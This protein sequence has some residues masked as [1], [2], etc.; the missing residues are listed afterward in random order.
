MKKSRKYRWISL[1]LATFLLLQLFGCGTS[2]ISFPADDDGGFDS[3]TESTTGTSTISVLESTGTTATTTATTTT[4]K[5][6]TKT[7]TQWKFYQVVS[8]KEDGIVVD[9]YKNGYIYV[10]LT[11]SSLKIRQLETVA[12]EFAESD[13]IPTSGTFQNFDGREL[14]Y[15]YVLEKPKS[16]RLTTAGEPT[17]G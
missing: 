17:F 16:I 13:L 4:D 10:K 2:D 3:S 14:H 9:M 5:I 11:D 1:V 7:D 15:S 6:T 12:M 8:V